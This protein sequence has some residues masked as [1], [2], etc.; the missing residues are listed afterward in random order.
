MSSL[1]LEVTP[2]LSD[3]AAVLAFSGW[4][5]AGDAASSA[6]R[7]LQ[8]ATQSVTLGIIDPEVFF[9]FTV[10]R[11]EV[12]YGEG[13]IREIEWPEF[14]LQYGNAGA[15]RDL[16]T[17][18]GP[19]PHLRWREYCD[20]F[21]DLLH[22]LGVRRVALLGAYLADVLYSLPVQ[23]TGFATDEELMRTLG[24]QA[25]SYEGPTGIVGVLS[26]RLRDEGFEVASLWAGLPHYINA[27]PNPRGALAL[28]QKLTRFLSLKIDEAPLAKA[29]AEYEERVS[30]L[31]ASDPALSEYV[32][33]LKRREFAQ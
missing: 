32:K 16:V 5:D 18:I 24:L 21:I 22:E 28:I 26:T 10:R 8:D 20:Q 29:A 13:K 2:T 1:R 23:V 30:A 12:R 7:Y 14:S 17:G 9:D 3:P 6:L 27:A 33:E 11:P 31:V 4:N 15:S 25:S 19:E